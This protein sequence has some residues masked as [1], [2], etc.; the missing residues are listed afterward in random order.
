MGVRPEGVREKEDLIET[1][2][3][4]GHLMGGRREEQEE[5]EDT[6]QAA[7]VTDTTDRCQMD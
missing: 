6:G 4:M 2:M 5:E 3:L 7:S 1:D